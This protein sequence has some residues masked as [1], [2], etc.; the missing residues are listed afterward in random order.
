MRWG[1]RPSRIGPIA[2][3]RACGLDITGDLGAELIRAR[4]AELVPQARHECGLYRVTVDVAAPI[5]EICLEYAVAAAE[6]GPDAEARRRGHALTVHRR[7]HRIDAVARQQTFARDSQVQR[8][9]TERASALVAVHDRAFDGVVAAEEPRGI[10]DVAG[11]ERVASARG[12]DDLA[13]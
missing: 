8:R 6:G 5:E 9:E 1:D 10:V 13:V 7:P 4:E 2:Q 12:T 3:G 11:E